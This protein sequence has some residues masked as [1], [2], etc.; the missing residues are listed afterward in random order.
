MGHVIALLTVLARLSRATRGTHTTAFGYFRELAFELR[1]NRS[2]RVRRYVHVPRTI[3][4]ID[5]QPSPPI[6]SPRRPIDD[7]PHTLP[8]THSRKVSADLARGYYLA[9]EK[10]R[11]TEALRRMRGSHLGSIVVEGVA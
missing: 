9:Q 6:P 5:T 2:R 10:R 3:A 11:N 4:K 8:P 1:R 7:R